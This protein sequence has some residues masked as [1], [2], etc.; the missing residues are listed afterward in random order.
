MHRITISHPEQA[1]KALAHVAGRQ[2]Q[3]HPHARRQ[4]DHARKAAN[5][6]RSVA[7]STPEPMRSRSPVFIT[8]STPGSAT[9]PADAAPRSTKAKRTGAGGRCSL[10]RLRQ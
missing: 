8:N 3:I 5:T 7:W 4:V 1:V 2:A 10:N 9:L 6:V